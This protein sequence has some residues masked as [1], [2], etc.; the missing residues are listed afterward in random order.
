MMT[1]RRVVVLSLAV[2]WTVSASQAQDSEKAFYAGKTVRMVR[3]GKV[4]ALD[5]A[6]AGTIAAASAIATAGT[7]RARAMA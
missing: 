3:F 2:C 6:A 7:K 5:C 1:M 4:A